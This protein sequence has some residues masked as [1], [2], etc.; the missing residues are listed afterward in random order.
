LKQLGY[1]IYIQLSEHIREG[2]PVLTSKD[3][4]GIGNSYQLVNQEAIRSQL[5]IKKELFEVCK[6]TFIHLNFEPVCDC[7][8]SQIL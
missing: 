3:Y 2:Q 1:Y 5:D 6:I 7:G 4:I 8:L